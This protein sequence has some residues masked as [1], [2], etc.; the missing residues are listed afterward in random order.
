MPLRL[1]GRAP[2][3]EF[4]PARRGDRAALY[5]RPAH[6]GDQ[7]QHRPAD[8]DRGLPFGGAVVSVSGGLGQPAA[9]G[10]AVRLQWLRS[11]AAGYFALF[12]RRPRFAAR[13]A[14]RDPLR[15]GAG[16]A[17]VIVIVAAT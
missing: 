8:H 16:A 3:A 12:S 1:R 6:R 10:A 14:W 7:Y 4:R 9:E 13:P 17:L 5:Q 11:N 15:V 2:R